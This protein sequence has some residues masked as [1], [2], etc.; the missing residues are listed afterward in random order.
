MQI[1]RTAQLEG[2]KSSVYALEQGPEPHLIFSGGSDNLIVE[3]NLESH[4][5]SRLLARMPERIFAL[6]YVEEK[7]LLLAG[8]YT[9]GIHVID[10]KQG[11]EIQIL[12]HHRSIIFEMAILPDRSGF[13]VLS[14][15]GSFSI[16]KMEDLSLISTHGIGPFKL[17]SLD[18]HPDG[19][20]MA[21]GS[22][23]GYIRIFDVEHFSEKQ[24]LEGHFKGFSVNAVRYIDKGKRLISGSRDAYLVEWDVSNNYSFSKGFQPHVYAIY[25]IAS[26]P[27]GKYLAS[28]SRDK[29]VKIW[30]AE[31][32]KLLTTI[33][34][35]DMQAHSKSV[36][37][38]LWSDFNAQLITTGDDRSVKAWEIKNDQE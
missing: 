32:L 33:K 13:I 30:D 7:H 18:F 24:K 22:E 37:K 29:T 10:L 20:E 36:N 38:I 31:N 17:R 25:G 26:S 9:G 8:S 5:K 2:H 3:W 12:Q 4:V 14:G 16:W 34:G 19:H 1:K 23:D 35:Q 6:K 11:K 15:D 21:L 27:D 28:G